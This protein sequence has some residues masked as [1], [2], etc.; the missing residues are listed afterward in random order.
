VQFRVGVEEDLT[1]KWKLKQA[2]EGYWLAT[3]NDNFYAS[4]GAIAV[5]A[6]PARAAISAMN[7]I[8]S[9]NTS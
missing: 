7:S 5:P 8:W 6:I 4:S 3:S 2:F 1:K 9:L